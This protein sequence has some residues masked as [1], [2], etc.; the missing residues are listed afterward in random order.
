MKI[1]LQY[2][3][4]H[5]LYKTYSIADSGGSFRTLFL[6]GWKISKLYWT[7]VAEKND[8]YNANRS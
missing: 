6:I 8:Q 7:P 4:L 3:I 1:L 5:V 2:Y